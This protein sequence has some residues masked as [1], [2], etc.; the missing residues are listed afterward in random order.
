MSPSNLTIHS[1]LRVGTLNV[2]QG[3]VRKLP[4]ILAHC[5]AL[6]FDI[7]ALQE[8]G[9]PALLHH[10]LP[11]YSLSMS[12]ATN[13][14]DGGVGLLLSHTLTPFI[15]SYRRSPSGRLHGV[16]LELTKGQ[17]TLIASVYMP[18][19][20]DHRSP[21]DR[22]TLLSHDLYKQLIEWTRNMQHTIIL[23]DLNETLT[24]YDRYPR[25]SHPLP[26]G[27]DN[28]SSHP[29]PIQSLY[30]EDFID[31]YRALHPN[32]S[33]HPGF[34]HEV[35]SRSGNTSSRIDYIWT[36][37]FPQSFFDQC[38]INRKLNTLSHHHILYLT[39]SFPH[40]LPSHPTAVNCSPSARI[41]NLTSL[42]D[43]NKKAFIHD[44]DLRLSPLHND[45][46]SFP[47][48]PDSN[49]LSSLASQLN[50]ITHA[51]AYR[52][53]PLTSAPSFQSKC[54][55]MLQR[56]RKDLSR[57][58]HI[59]NTLTAEGKSFVNCPEWYRIYQRCIHSHKIKWRVNA[60]TL[61]PIS[62]MTW[63]TETKQ[64]IQQSRSSFRR[65]G[66]KM[67]HFKP[68]FFDANSTSTVHRMLK[69]F[70]DGPLL[71]VVDSDGA[72]TTQPE[73]FKQVMLKH[74]TKVFDLPPHLTASKTRDP[75]KPDMLY[76]KT[77]V[78]HQ[79]Y[80]GLMD[81][82]TE[83]DLLDVASDASLTSA[84]GSDGVSTGVWKIALQES[85]MMR[86]IVCTLFC[87]CIQTHSFPLT[88]KDSIII[89]FVKKAENERTMNN[90][91]PISLQNC[92]GKLFSKILAR[93]LGKIFTQHPILNPSQRGFLPGGTTIKCI[94]EILDAWSWSR[95]KNK[96]LYTIFYDI[97]QA[98]DSVQIN[99]LEIALTRIRLPAS[100]I[101]LIRD[102]LTGLSSAILTSY[103]LTKPFPV[104]RSVRQGDPLAPLLF[105]I[106]MDPLHDGLHTNPFTLKQHGCTLTFNNSNHI[107]LPSLGYADD[108]TVICN[109]L[110]D[111]KVQN[112]WVSYFT[113]FNRLLLNATK[114][115]L[116]GR[117]SDTGFPCVTEQAIRDA[118]IKIQDHFL[119]P[120]QHTQ[121]IR[122]LGAHF[123]FD[124]SWKLQ[125]QKA[126]E[127]IFKFT[128]AVNKFKVSIAHA[129]KMFN[130]F[131]LPRL[132]LALHYVH[133]PK[134][135]HWVKT[136]D[137][138]IIG[139]IKHCAASSSRLSHSAVALS[140][141]LILPSWIESSVKI[142]ELF[143]R[144]NSKDDRWGKLGR[145]MMRM[146][147]GSRIS[148]DT[149]LPHANSNSLLKR[150]AHLVVKS[151]CCKIALNEE[152]Q[153][154]IARQK[155]LFELDSPEGMP[156]SDQCTSISSS[157]RLFKRHEPIYIAH[158]YWSGWGS[159][160]P[161]QSIR[162][163]TDGS[164][165]SS[166]PNISSSWALVLESHA[167][168]N[169]MLALPLHSEMF[170]PSDL[171]EMAIF[172]G[173][174]NCTQGIYSAELQ[175]IA[176]SLAIFPLSYS[177]H[178]FSDS[179]A[180]LAGIDKYN[181]ETN[182]RRRM[183]MQ[184]RPLLALIQNLMSRR[185]KVGGST[186]FSHVRSHTDGVDIQ[187]IGN[188]VADY[189]AE[190]CRKNSNQNR[191]LT[192]LQL[193]L[194]TLEPFLQIF[195]MT[196]NLMIIDD[197]RLFAKL[198]QKDQALEHWKHDYRE[199]QGM[200]ASTGMID[201]G[202]VIMKFGSTQ[203]QATF[204][205]L[206]TNTIDRYWK[207]V[208]NNLMPSVEEKTYI[209]LQCE[210][211]TCKTD[212][213]LS[214]FSSCPNSKAVS[215]RLQLRNTL[216][217]SITD[218]QSQSNWLDVNRRLAL[219]SFLLRL[220]PPSAE[221]RSVD[222]RNRHIT[223]CMMGAFTSAEANA[224]SKLLSFPIKNPSKQTPSPMDLLRLHS[225][226]HFTHTFNDWKT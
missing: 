81:A 15:R 65:E 192:A 222:D 10:S 166:P 108:T 18:S 176:R 40:S 31:C 205:H 171:K 218:S 100:F 24:M 94:D 209:H 28:P 186:Q 147:C 96:E 172:G 142:S 63:I 179:K 133:G 16:I 197:V 211:D 73:E 60:F 184:S 103:G 43:E 3:F 55:L 193:P 182:E 12:A 159:L 58:L 189:Q 165:M 131:L 177:I 203:D 143:L 207:I 213:N 17:Q 22:H 26:S 46:A 68:D 53:L 129:I 97:Q 109:T 202:R 195:S 92:L 149:I 88:W 122:Y 138:L 7:L 224:A 95:N 152:P 20:L 220:F 9:D 161:A 30:Q 23:G 67:Q 204:I 78:Q 158:D 164:F 51:S 124:G 130:I 71:S 123:S 169:N 150:T 217:Q 64:L 157:I 137:R 105:I 66:K 116:V 175:A 144:M 191:P 170:R 188:R 214:H 80:D 32:A 59:A 47:H 141:N 34:T 154:E 87:A 106:L 134:S 121:A 183:R 45:L 173:S 50:T 57:I 111:L 1:R 52:K 153:R 151:L 77:S 221:T 86:K 41:P 74:F 48:T 72:L 180:A 219:S 127:V 69:G 113:Q 126:R 148:N 225:V 42:T 145:I 29:T 178:I 27:R 101:A 201:L 56:Q 155:H 79:W 196:S 162:I 146:E 76:D 139:A 93:R 117:T 112:D 39:L 135:S 210:F 168:V 119:L 163:Y 85:S 8:I 75:S 200:F 82:V 199:S 84:P 187:S 35:R 11:Q 156:D 128:T 91:R 38:E 226:K 25:P 110:I 36:K 181:R 102:S 185:M 6:S 104:R 206:A 198:Q 54:M 2:G 125:Q 190:S 114:C 14:C 215:S 115:D 33:Q 90:I 37:G 136:C 194:Q 223:R 62:A 216:V 70:H 21:D 44:L 5:I 99:V 167:L 120:L 107:Y 83:E 212:M 140:C 19:G 13:H 89:P 174:I 61:H 132:E 98:Y 118:D 208:P 160:L 49:L 4:H